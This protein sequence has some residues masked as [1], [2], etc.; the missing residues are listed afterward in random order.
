MIGIAAGALTVPL[1]CIP[2]TIWLGQPILIV[3]GFSVLPH[4]IWGT[5]VGTVVAYGLLSYRKMRPMSMS[6]R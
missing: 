3:I 6:T 4:L 1:G 5:V 2:L